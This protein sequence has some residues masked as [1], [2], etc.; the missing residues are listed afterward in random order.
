MRVAALLAACLGAAN[1]GQVHLALGMTPDETSVQWASEKEGGLSEVLYGTSPGNL[2]MRQ[3]GDSRSYHANI[4]RE[5]WYTR[6]A[7]MTGL[8]PNTKYYYKVGDKENGYSD[9]F[10]FVNKRNTPPYQHI[11]FGDMGSA[12]AFTI[13]DACTQHDKVCTATTC[14]KNTS[15]GL[16]S[17]VDTAD[18]FLH[19]GDFAYNLDTDEGKLGDQ[20]FENIEQLA[21]RVPYMVSHGNHEDAPGS[22]AQYIERFRSQPSNAIP[23][24]YT[25]MNGETT[26]TMYF[27]WDHALV[28]YISF[29]TELFHAPVAEYSDKVTKHT[30]LSWLKDDLIK[31]NKNRDA[32]PWIVVHGH[33]PLYS[34]ANSGYDHEVRAALEDLFF[35]YGVDFSV[36]GHQH[37]YE[38]SFPTYKDKSQTNFTNPTATIYVVTGAAGSHEMHTPFTTQQPSWSAFRSNTFG[39]TRMIVH[40]ASHIHWQQVQT[41]PAD[42]PQSDYGRVIDD[43]WIVQNSH[44]PFNPANAPTEIPETCDECKTVDHFAP[45]LNLGPSDVPLYKLIQQYRAEHGELAWAKKLQSVLDKLNGKTG[46]DAEWEDGLLD[47]KEKTALR[48]IDSNQNNQ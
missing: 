6:V 17:E 20:F 40:N 33:R 46:D 18:M 10:S 3:Q 25:T 45:L 19:A 22:L 34:S 26:N 30:F 42:F 23:P 37:D 16:V 11:L 41:D 9:V 44:G 24:T 35:Q 31:A 27:S 48:W 32:F 28:H 39:Y 2:T 1:A 36:N 7:V 12:A 21:S 43:I 47:K 38:R 5:K 13:C 4:L 29:S 14:A 15:V 8:K